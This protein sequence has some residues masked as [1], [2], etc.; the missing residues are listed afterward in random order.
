MGPRDLDSVG[1]YKWEENLGEPTKE[2]TAT[3]TPTP[4]QEEPP[5]PTST[6]EKEGCFIATAAYG[7][8]TSEKLDILRDFRDNV[9]ERNLL[10]NITVNFYYDVSPPL[11]D[12]IS[13]HENLR[14]LVREIMIDP[15]VA[16][17]N[18]TQN[19]WNN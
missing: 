9:L 8:P 15:I 16:V 2:P 13:E 10:G 4:T 12:F 7:T 18:I 11:A 3:P 5:T 1:Y 19:I 17:L 14:I 6:P